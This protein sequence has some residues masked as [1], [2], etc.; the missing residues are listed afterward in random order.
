L[1][2]GV[3]GNFKFHQHIQ[4]KKTLHKDWQV[5]LFSTHQEKDRADSSPTDS[6]EDSGS[7]AKHLFDVIREPIHS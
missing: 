5:N 1:Q 2:K 3:D 4:K 7:E 6:P